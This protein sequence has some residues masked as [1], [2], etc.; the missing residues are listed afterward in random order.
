MEN[1][2]AGSARLRVAGLNIR[3]FRGIDRLRLELTDADGEP[4]DMAVFAGGNGSGKTAVLEALVLL[5]TGST[6]F[7]PGDAAPL[8]EQVR[9]GARKAELSAHMS[10]ERGG[11]DDRRLLLN[12]ESRPLSPWVSR[13][14]TAVGDDEEREVLHGWGARGQFELPQIEY[15][16]ARREPMDLGKTV[17]TRGAR[18]QDE[19][20]RIRELKRRLVSAYYRRLRVQPS[21][22]S[23]IDAPFSRL[24]RFWERFSGD[25]R[26]L[27]V[28][29]VDNRP[30]SGEEVVL[31]EAKP[32]PEDITSL[33]MA[34]DLA[35]TREDIPRMVPIERLSSGQMALFAFAG[36]L[37][38]RDRPAD[39]VLIDEP[40]EHL[41]VQWQRQI[42]SALRELSPGTQ[43]LIATHSAEILDAALT[44]ERF[45]LV[46]ESDPRARIGEDSSDDDGAVE[47]AQ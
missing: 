26:V 22:A 41:H 6:S 2:T 43:F 24:Q 9:F 16:S 37:V 46:E 35:P 47:A 25:G 29:P 8:H 21:Q 19:A 1:G 33:A 12:I 20:T 34:R 28:I 3:D 7:L 18:S 23:T 39:V 44:Y 42:L 40:E 17:D 13:Q 4:L 32:I 5:L 31:R 27:D 10:A 38:F 45:I 11:D 15:F 14:F 30:D 36:P